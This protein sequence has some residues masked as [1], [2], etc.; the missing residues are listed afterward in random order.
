MIL[1][2]SMKRKLFA[3][4]LALALVVAMVFVIAPSAKAEES[5]VIQAQE[6]GSITVDDGKILDLNG[7]SVTVTVEEG[8]TLYVIDTANKNKD[9]ET[10]AGKLTKNGT[11]MIETVSQAPDT[12]MRYLATENV[13]GTYSA[14]PFNLTISQLG[15]NTKKEAICL[16]ASFM[17]NDKVIAVIDDYGFIV[18]GTG[19]TAKEKYPFA[20]N[21]I[22]AYADL[23]GSLADDAALDVQKTAKAYIKIGKE[24]VYSTYEAKITPREV[25]KGLNND[26][27]VAKAT[28]NQRTSIGTL[29]ENAYLADLFTSFT[30]K[31]C[32]HYAKASATCLAPETCKNC[33]ETFGGVAEHKDDNADYKCDW[34]DTAMPKP[35]YVEKNATELYAYKPSTDVYSNQGEIF[36]RNDVYGAV[37]QSNWSVEVVAKTT[38]SQKLYP[39]S[40]FAYWPDVR[41]NYKAQGY[42]YAAV[43][44]ALSEGA[45]IRASDVCLPLRQVA[46][47]SQVV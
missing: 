39:D 29:A 13:D 15:L 31:T 42:Q 24:T 27:T 3:I 4:F 46:M 32:T 7:K 37:F 16:R 35:D 47:L 34:C 43:D 14:H 23:T 33:D 12:K 10:G 2:R 26:T 11:G 8:K 44:F 36:G 5:T 20:G 40:P 18:D 25:L 38:A 6:D 17:A 9:G 28:E 22:N 21:F 41:N 30:D 1:W 45:T 19:H